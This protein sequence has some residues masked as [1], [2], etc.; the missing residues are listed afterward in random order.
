VFSLGF[1]VFCPKFKK[2]KTMDWAFL[3]PCYRSDETESTVHT[4]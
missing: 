2:F 3:W 1:V 4:K